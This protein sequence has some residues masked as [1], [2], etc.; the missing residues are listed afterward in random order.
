[1]KEKRLL[2][3]TQ[4]CLRCLEVGELQ[5]FMGALDRLNDIAREFALGDKQ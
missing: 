3:A 5:G 4:T 1:M 2:V